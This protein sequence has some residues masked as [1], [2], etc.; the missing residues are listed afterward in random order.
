MQPP[1]VKLRQYD[2][3][4]EL[5][6]EQITVLFSTNLRQSFLI[7][8]GW[9]KSRMPLV[10]DPTVSVTAANTSPEVQVFHKL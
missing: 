4:T 5:L 7:S 10:V 6:F 3:L 2:F 1:S 8:S 9:I